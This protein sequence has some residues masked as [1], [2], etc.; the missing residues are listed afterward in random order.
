MI[1]DYIYDNRITFV[2]DPDGDN[3]ESFQKSLLYIQN[4][5]KP[6]ENYLKYGYW[7]EASGHFIKD[8]IKVYLEYTNWFG[9]N[10]KVDINISDYSLLKVR[11]W[12]E[13]IYN[14][15]HKK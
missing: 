12:A 1:K 11:Q 15:I 7:E 8:G 5:I 4:Q 6:D 14:E 2:I 10:L 13:D 3:F 9:T